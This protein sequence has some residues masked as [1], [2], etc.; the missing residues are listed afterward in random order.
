MSRQF[1]IP[2]RDTDDARSAIARVA[3][4]AE[5]GDEIVVLIVSTV[6]E[7]EIVD[8]RPPSQVLDPLATT[9]GVSSEPRA[10]HDR[11]VMMNRE[12]LMEIKGREMCDALSSE[13]ASLH[14]R[15]FEGR[16]EALFSDEAGPTIRDYANDLGVTEI[17]A[18]REFREDLDAETRE[19]VKAV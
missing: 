12:E 9:G 8:S 1:L 16:V 10:A 2:V 18:T 3:S 7:G 17:C 19:A 13:I 4:I 11:P 5:A 14:D 15:G 6:P